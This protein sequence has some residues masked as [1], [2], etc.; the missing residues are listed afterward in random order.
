MKIVPKKDSGVMK[1]RGYKNEI[2][3]SLQGMNSETTYLEQ[4]KK[5]NSHQSLILLRL[6]RIPNGGSGLLYGLAKD[7]SAELLIVPSGWRTARD[8]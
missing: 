6:S 2:Q 1:E 7:C 5:K 8:D 4:A 3:D